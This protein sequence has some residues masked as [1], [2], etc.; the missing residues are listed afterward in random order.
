MIPRTVSCLFLL[1]S[2][3][4]GALICARAVVVVVVKAGTEDRRRV[5]DRE[6]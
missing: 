6:S 1:F 2:S 3:F 5:C 4:D